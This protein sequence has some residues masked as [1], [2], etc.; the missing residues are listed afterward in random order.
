MVALRPSSTPAAASANAPVHTDST[1]RTAVDGVAQGLAQRR[2]QR[3]APRPGQAGTPTRSAVRARSRSCGTTTSKPDVVG[4]G[5]GRTPQTREVVG[6][7]ALVGA[8]QPED[9]AEDAQLE[10]GHPVTHQHR[11]VVHASPT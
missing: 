5:P 6:G 7:Q 10:G 8:V 3:V 9:L 4:T 1:G 11:D 2:V